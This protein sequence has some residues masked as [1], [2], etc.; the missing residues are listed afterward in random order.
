MISISRRTRLPLQ[1]I[2]I[3]DAIT[4]ALFGLLML[5]ATSPLAEFT[6]FPVNLLRLA[7]LVLIP[8]VAFLVMQVRRPLVPSGVVYGIITVNIA[9]ALGCLVAIITPSF[10][11]N[12]YGVMFGLIQ[13]IGVLAFAALQYV[14]RNEQ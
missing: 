3:A 9:W 7:G 4:C 12:A 10:E 14:S 6:D 13:I 11:P 2:L 5:V 8:W 1:V